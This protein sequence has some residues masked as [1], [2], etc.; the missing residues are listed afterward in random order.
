[1]TVGPS[2]D[3]NAPAT[4]GVDMSNRWSRAM[5]ALA[6]VAV[7]AVSACGSSN[8]VTA[9]PTTA[10]S[11]TTLE[12][13][14]WVLGK[15]TE[16]GAELGDV[17]ASATFTNGTVSGTSGCN[18]YNGPYK[19]DGD[20][21]TI[22]PNLV[23]TQMACGP[24]ETA[25]EKVFLE[26]LPKVASYSIAGSTLTLADS[27]GEAL[28]VFD[29]SV[30]S[31]AIVGSWNVLS[32]Y[33]GDAVVSVVSGSTVTADFKDGQITGSAGCNSYMGPYTIDGDSITIGPLAST[34]KACSSDELSKQE[35]SYLAALEV[36][37]TFAVTGNRLD[38][39]R[40]GGTFAATME[41]A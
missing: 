7:L 12:E 20:K 5:V 31:D 4:R 24:A 26:R 30:G 2:V 11:S 16:L 10:G 18:T 33:T 39:F 22:G 9:S 41:K 29:A 21:L 14:T 19:V 40:E 27:S 23:S 37:K 38:L 13:T 36:A 15:K 1:M 3:Q 28:L 34:R 35:A 25:V 8:D 17:V 6:G 32:Y